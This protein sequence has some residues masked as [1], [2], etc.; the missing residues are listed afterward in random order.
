M[1]LNVWSPWLP[2]E[3]CK[4]VPA[5]RD[6]EKE[7]RQAT[8]RAKCAEREFEKARKD[9]LPIQDGDRPYTV[10]MIHIISRYRRSRRELTKANEVLRQ[11]E[12]R[13]RYR[14]KQK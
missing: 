7:I 3:Y 9:Y 10:E 11:L 14:E 8:R 4:S 6:L 13:K 1:K 5:H 12:I 2:Q